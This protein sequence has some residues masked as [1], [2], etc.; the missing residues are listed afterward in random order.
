ML[1]DAAGV[2]W[3]SVSPVKALPLAA[4]DAVSPVYLP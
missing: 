2:G 3:P 4:L 1:A